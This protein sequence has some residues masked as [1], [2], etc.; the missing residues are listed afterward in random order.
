[1]GTAIDFGLAILGV[2]CG[3]EM[4]QKIAKAIIY[5]DVSYRML[6]EEKV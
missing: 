6:G 1:M 5:Q 2:F 4:A 3:Q